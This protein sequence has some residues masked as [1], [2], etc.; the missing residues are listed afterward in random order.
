MKLDS[1]AGVRALTMF[2]DMIKDGS[3]P[4]DVVNW[5]QGDIPTQLLST[6][7]WLPWLWDAG[8]SSG[9]RTTRLI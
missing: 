9:L 1:E 8:E 3:M 5:T 2:T 6:A 4:K 7:R